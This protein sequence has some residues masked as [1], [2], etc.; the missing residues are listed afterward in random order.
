MTVE[1]YLRAKI[2][3]YPF[4]TDVIEST[5]VS[6]LFAKPTVL[7][8]LNLDDD[9]AEVARDCEL[10]QSLRYAEST[11]YYAVSGVF[12]G[13]S[14][15]EQVGDVKI[16]LSGFTLTEADRD[17]YRQLADTIREELGCEV[18]NNPNA[19]SGMF[20]ATGLTEWS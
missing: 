3:G 4:T 5:L 19:D 16:T 10:T 9:V 18:E 14:R 11:L 6:P 17:Y 15:S 2:P 7:K 1:A 12:S 8:E 13:G 20:D